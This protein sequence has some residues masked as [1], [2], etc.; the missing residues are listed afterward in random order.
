[1]STDEENIPSEPRAVQSPGALNLSATSGSI[2]ANWLYG[3]VD[4]KNDTLLVWSS[5]GEEVGRHQEPGGS[6]RYTINGLAPDKLYAVDAF[7]VRGGEMS[8]SPL[9]KSITTKPLAARPEP[10]ANLVANPQLELVDL[11]WTPTNNTSSYKLQFGREPSGDVYR[12]ET[13]T[14]PSHTFDRLGSDTLY[15]FKVFAVNAAGESDATR[16]TAKTLEYTG[17]VDP[18]PPE[19]PKNLQVA[20]AINTMEVKWSAAARATGYVINYRT[21]PGGPTLTINTRLLTE[22]LKNLTPGTLYAIDVIAENAQGPSLPAQ[23]TERTL[24]Q[25]PLKP[26]PYTAEV[27]F[28]QVTLSWGGEAPEYEVSW[29]LMDKYPD[30]IALYLTDR[31]EQI[32][33]DLLPLTSYYFHVRAKN[34]SAYS[35][36]ARTSADIGPDK[37]Q[38]RNVRH[39]GRTFNEAW[40]KWDEPEDTA[41]LLGYDVTSP[42]I[43]PVQ[44][45]APEVIITGLTPGVARVFTIQPRRPPER[46]PALP[47]TL[48]VTTQDSVPPTLPTKL[49]LIPLTSD[50]AELNWSASQDNVGVTGHEVRRNGGA[51]V[52]AIGTTHIFTGLK[53]SA[54][55]TFEVRGKDAAGNLSIIARLSLESS[56]QLAPNAPSNFRVKPGIVYKLEWDKPIPAV[57]KGYK[58]TIT[59]PQGSASSQP[60]QESFSTLLSPLIRYDVVIVAYNEYGDSVALRGTIPG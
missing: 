7:G 44:T 15:W 40:L 13:S 36:S 18:T 2:S 32:F 42:G 26:S 10:P 45:T 33:Q 19:T 24:F 20:P 11:K 6:V 50:S 41:F 60:T 23:V 43:T 8:V 25:H 46:R 53:N 16:I 28:S 30:H 57:Q 3:A 21:E 12:T 35:E 27:R 9:R 5:A 38:P 48:S 22:T 56:Q 31:K 14:A 54:S 17:P 55:E 49:K 1:M 37:T 29:G 39:P 51:W 4:L 47:A 59:S 58:V 52:P 34:G